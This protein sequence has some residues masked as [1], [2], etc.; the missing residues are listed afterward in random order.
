[1]AILGN[2]GRAATFT[3]SAGDTR[4]NWSLSWHIGKKKYRGWGIYRTEENKQTPKLRKSV[5]LGV[6]SS[7]DGNRDSLFT[8]N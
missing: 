4:L 2:D 6:Y 3:R 7:K 1:M 5:R 8:T